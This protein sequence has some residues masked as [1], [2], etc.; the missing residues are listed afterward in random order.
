MKLAIM[1]PYIFPYIGYFQL[2]HSVDKFVI[3]D[4]VTFIKQGWINRNN[5]LVN[6]K[7]HLFTIPL[8]Q[9]TS[10]KNISDTKIS[11]SLYSNWYNKF[12]KTLIANYKKAPYFKTVFYLL[13]NILKDIS[14]YNS[15]SD[16]CRQGVKAIAGYL[17]IQTSIQ[18]SSS[19][20]NNSHLSASERVIDICKIEKA[21]TY[22]NPIG[23][24]ELYSKVEFKNHLID[25]YFLKSGNVLYSQF[26]YE[27]V[28]NLS[29]IDTL[30]F[31]SKEE[32]SHILKNYTLN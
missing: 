2:L 26:N 12:E 6:G 19:F 28:S 14:K 7:K 24:S 4:D 5:I 20:Y 32:V 17:E 15:I 10:F 13:T 23:G 25:L 30:M 3:Y 9:A 1:Q 27:F 11:A 18:A 31:N 16:L 22:I 29:V 8:E 21:S